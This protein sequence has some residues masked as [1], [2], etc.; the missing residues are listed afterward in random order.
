MDTFAGIG[1]PVTNAVIMT[2]RNRNFRKEINDADPK[3]KKKG[4]SD[5]FARDEI[6]SKGA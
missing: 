5:P 1:S 3:N 6:T 4:R 2:F